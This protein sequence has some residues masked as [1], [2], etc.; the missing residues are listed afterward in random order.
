MANFDN[1]IYDDK[2]RAD[3]LAIRRK[4]PDKIF[5]LAPYEIETAPGFYK[6]RIAVLG[7][8][9]LVQ[10]PT[11]TIFSSASDARSWSRKISGMIGHDRDTAAAIVADVVR[12]EEILSYGE[13][14]VAPVYLTFGEIQTLIETGVDAGYDPNGVED[15]DPEMEGAM[16]K[17]SAALEGLSGG[18]EMRR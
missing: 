11:D 14:Q 2:A 16:V 9:S 18:Y 7:A 3:I 4:H 1:A 5:A 12:R 8:A 17:L 10:D 6:F 15:N 13:E